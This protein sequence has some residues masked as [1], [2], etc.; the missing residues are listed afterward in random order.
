[1][2]LSPFFSTMD[3]LAQRSSHEQDHFQH[4]ASIDDNLWRVSGQ[5]ELSVLADTLDV[6][7]PLDESFHTLDALV[8]SELLPRPKDGTHPTFDYAGL[9]IHIEEIS[10]RRIL[11]A[12]IARLDT[13]E[14]ALP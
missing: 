9:R 12:Q 3:S 2:L 13:W 1:M 14:V 11:W 4:I 8:R 10:G 7:L 6:P 5:C